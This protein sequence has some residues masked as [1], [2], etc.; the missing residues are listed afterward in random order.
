M[1]RSKEKRGR[2]RNSERA[3]LTLA[4]GTCFEGVAFGKL[5]HP[6]TPVGGEVVF[7]TTMTGYQEVLTDPSYAGQIMAFTYP[8]IGNVGCNKLDVESADVFLEGVV[9]RNQ[10][11]VVSNFRSQESLND[12]LLRYSKM[13]ISDIDTRKL[14]RH[15][16]DHGA[17]MGVMAVQDGSLRT[18]DLREHALALGSMEGKDFVQYVSCKLPYT[19]DQL[20]WNL[21]TNS[22]PSVSAD[23][24]FLDRMWSLLTQE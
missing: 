8:H 12:Y 15:I 20:P 6:S 7:N 5:A 2:M 10:S 21:R 14:V 19:W 18:D 24:L 22:Y 9:I 1:N 4:D 3:V 17:Q 11:R 13:G 23:R 16:R